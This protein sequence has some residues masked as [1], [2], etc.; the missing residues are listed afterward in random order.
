[1]KTE[2]WKDI[3]DYEGLYQISNLGR[4]KSLKFGKER[5][6]KG[7]KD[8]NGY[9]IVCLHKDGNQ[10]T[11]KVH[12]LVAIAFLGHIPSGMS[13]VVDHINRIKTDNRLE[14]L[15]IIT[16]RENLSKDKRW[17]S[18]YTSKYI[19]VHWCKPRNKWRAQIRINKITKHLGYFKTELEASEVYKSK[20]ETI[21]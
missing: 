6:L 5:I 11:K 14:N 16:N 15:Q 8:F 2:I 18:K 9:S 20:L 3:K 17:S 1:M 7:T 19:G 12:Q 13:L 4:V 10:K 21:K